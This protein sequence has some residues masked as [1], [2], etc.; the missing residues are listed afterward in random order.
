MEL[1]HAP[2][3]PEAQRPQEA[4]VG[5]ARRKVHKLRG[6]GGAGVRPPRSERERIQNLGDV[7][8]GRG[9]IERGSFEMPAPLQTLPSSEDIGQMGVRSGSSS[10]RNLEMAEV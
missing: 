5:I 10:R 3:D 7:R 8:L 1:W 9:K 2:R 6:D 4:I